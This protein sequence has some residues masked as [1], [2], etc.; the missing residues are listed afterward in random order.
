MIIIIVITC[1]NAGISP[2]Q[3]SSN[4]DYTSVSYHVHL[5]QVLAQLAQVHVQG[6]ATA[7]GRD[8]DVGLHW[9]QGQVGHQP[10]QLCRSRSSV[11]DEHIYSG[12]VWVSQSCAERTLELSEI[13]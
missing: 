11:S 1:W 5:A 8:V 9:G 4:I 2:F 7:N 13:M 10:V 6:E 12:G 3:S